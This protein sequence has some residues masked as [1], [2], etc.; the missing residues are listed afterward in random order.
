MA[1]N[2][3]V[4]NAFIHGKKRT[5]KHIYTDGTIIFSYGSHFPLAFK[6]NGIVLVNTTKYSSTTQRHQSMLFKVLDRS[7]HHSDIVECTTK[8]IQ[9]AI[10]RPDLPLVLYRIPEDASVDKLLQLLKEQCRK[11]GMKR[12]PMKKIQ[13]MIIS[14]MI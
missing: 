14:E 5:G 3:D 8:E 4:C 12:F 2:E 1:T 6:N 9:K 13:E 11:K 7:A 10:E